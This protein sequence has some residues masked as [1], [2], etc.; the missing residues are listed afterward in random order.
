MNSRLWP[1]E[2]QHGGQDG[3]DQAGG[4]RGGQHPSTNSMGRGGG[5][6]QWEGPDHG[7]GPHD[8]HRQ[9]ALANHPACRCWVRPGLRFSVSTS[10]ISNPCACLGRCCTRDRRQGGLRDLPSSNWGDLL[11]FGGFPA[12][13]RPR[14]GWRGS[15]P[16]PPAGRRGQRLLQL[17]ERCPLLSMCTTSQGQLPALGEA[18]AIT[19]GRRRAHPDAN[20]SC[21]AAAVWSCRRPATATADPPP[22]GWRR[23]VSP[24]P[25][26]GQVV[27][28]EE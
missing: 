20:I 7:R 24:A 2:A 11:L 8:G 13:H 10:V 18:V 23:S 3:G 9:Q 19:P 17:G 6:S 14:P 26:G 28:G 27:E 22:R 5:G 12:G 16:W 4:E 25:Q 21:P 1:T 15:A